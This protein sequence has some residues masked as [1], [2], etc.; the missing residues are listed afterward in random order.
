MRGL[1]RREKKPRFGGAFFMEL[2]SR[3]TRVEAMA[4]A[5]SVAP[6]GCA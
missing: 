4:V 6:T 5:T 2:V 3:S 1:A